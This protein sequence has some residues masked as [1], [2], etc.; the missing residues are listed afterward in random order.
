MVKPWSIFSRLLARFEKLQ[1]YI[2]CEITDSL[3]LCLSNPKNYRRQKIKQGPK[4]KNVQ[5]REW[6]QIRVKVQKRGSESNKHTM[7]WLS[8]TGNEGNVSL[9]TWINTWII[10]PWLKTGLY[11]SLAHS[12]S[13]TREEQQKHRCSIKRA[14]W[15]N[16]NKVHSFN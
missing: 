13:S 12:A 5:K 1:E 10:R 15:K 8:S 3:L 4:W 16:N 14:Q 9:D 11:T 2:R 6:R 7:L